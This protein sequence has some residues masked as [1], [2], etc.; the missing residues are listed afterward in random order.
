MSDIQAKVMIRQELK[1]QIAETEKKLKDLKEAYKK[2]QK[3]R[4]VITW[5]KRQRERI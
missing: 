4:V 5:N 2:M 3:D 1:K